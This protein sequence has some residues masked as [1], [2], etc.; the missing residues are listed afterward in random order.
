[1]W[2]WQ[3]VGFPFVMLLFYTSFLFPAYALGL[4]AVLNQAVEN[5]G[6]RSYNILLTLCVVASAILYWVISFWD[7]LSST[8]AQL[9]AG[10]IGP[11]TWAHPM[12]AFSAVCSSITVPVF[13][14]RSKRLAAVTVLV[15]GMFTVYA[16]Q[17]TRMEKQGWFSSTTLTNKQAFHIL[18]D[19]DTWVDKTAR[20]RKIQWWANLTEPRGGLIGSLAS[21]YFYGYTMLGGNMPQLPPQDEAR[22]STTKPLLVVSWNPDALEQARQTLERQGLSVKEVG[23]AIT[24]GDATLHLKLFKVKY[25]TRLASLTTGKGMQELPGLLKLDQILPANPFVS[26]QKEDVV[27][28]RTVQ[29]RWGYDAILPAEFP[30][31]RDRYMV[32]MRVRVVKGQIGFGVLNGTETDFYDRKFLD[33]DVDPQDVLLDVTHP[34]DSHKLI[35]ENG[36]WDR[37]PSEV[38]IEKLSVYAEPKRE[39]QVVS[40]RIGEK[41][42]KKR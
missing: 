33:E 2:A 7:G 1:V 24:N 32:H 27:R 3:A 18:L 8:Y 6:Q 13:W 37:M 4:A 12:W 40:K 35:I 41:A 21:I 14:L 9:H 30:A 34:G 29:S 23:T 5:L 16:L 15:L 11:W 10:V 36:D 28:L 22:L 25:A 38:V 19:A 39:T 42:G 31:D 17:L 20:E 26:I